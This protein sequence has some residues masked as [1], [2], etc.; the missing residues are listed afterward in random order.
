MVKA[1]GEACASTGGGGSKG[2]YFERFANT[3]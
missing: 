2:R 3:P 1:E